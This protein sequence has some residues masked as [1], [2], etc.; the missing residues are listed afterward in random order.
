[1]K[2]V[3]VKKEWLEEAK[4]NAAEMGKLN[5]SITAGEGNLAGFVGEIVVHSIIGGLRHNT[6]NYDI[7]LNE[8]LIDVKTKRCTSAPRKNYE[9]S[10]AAFN[11]RQQCSHYVFCRVLEPSYSTCWVLGHL[12]KEEYFQKARF[13]EA[14]KVDERDHRGWTF[15]ADCYN[16]EIGALRPIDDL[17]P[18]I[19]MVG[20]SQ[21]FM[22]SKNELEE[23][24]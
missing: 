5:G 11:T 17:L 22:N 15:K 2:Q 1:M 12:P 8:H 9:C 21:F 19:E 18:S 16:I 14:G 20:S 23:A 6:K 7:K 4:Q 3:I 10:V 24:W 13:C